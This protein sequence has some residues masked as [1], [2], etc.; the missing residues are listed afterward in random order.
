MVISEMY[1]MMVVPINPADIPARIFA[2]KNAVQSLAT[3]STMI[4]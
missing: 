3:I 4:A 1:D 2:P